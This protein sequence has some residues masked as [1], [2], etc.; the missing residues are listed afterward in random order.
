MSLNV[1]YFFWI[2]QGSYPT[3]VFL[4]LLTGVYCLLSADGIGSG[5]LFWCFPSGRPCVRPSLVSGLFLWNNCLNFNGTIRCQNKICITLG[6]PC[7]TIQPRIIAPVK[8]NNIYI[9]Q[10]L[11][12]GYFLKT[13]G[14]SSK[15]VC[16]NL[17]CLEETCLSLCSSRST[18]SL[19]AIGPYLLNN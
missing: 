11:F 7:S 3:N 10:Y 16:W 8:L 17:Y 5:I 4:F 18:V 19:C 14:C 15:N 13:G 9:E 6:L 1:L 2:M 12:L